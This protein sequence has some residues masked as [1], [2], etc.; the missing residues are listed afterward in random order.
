MRFRSHAPIANLQQMTIQTPKS[1]PSRTEPVGSELAATDRP[2]LYALLA[3]LGLALFLRLWGITFG[4]PYDFTPD[5]VHEI[6]RALKL[7]AGEYAWT[8]GKGGLYYFLFVEYGLLY[9]FYWITGQV[10]NPNDF[11]LL[12]LENP[13]AFYI[14][15]RVTVAIMGT[16]TCF[17]I[18]IIG[19][20][21]YDWRTGLA[22]ALIGATAHYHGLWSH[23]INVD[24]GMTLAVWASILSYI[25]YER[26]RQLR[27]LLAAGA[28][29][30]I[31]YAFKLPGAVVILLLLLAIATRLHQWS[32]PLQPIKEAGLV[33]LAMLVT[34]AIIAPENIHGMGG[35]FNNFSS[36]LANDSNE[37]LA[38]SGP[39]DEDKIDAAVDEVT[40]YR[41]SLNYLKILF[42][43]TNIVLTLGA[44][45][46]AA[47]GLRRRHRW[48]GL[49]FALIVI[50]LGVMALADRPG[51]ERYMLPIVPAFWLLGARAAVLLSRQR[52]RLMITIIACIIVIPLFSLVRQ[53]YTWTRP[54]TRVLAKDWIE[55]NIPS[56]AKILMDGMRYR[57]IGSPPLN[58]D[59][60]TVER[61]VR[62]A[63]DQDG[64]L[65]RG[66]SEKSLR[67]YSEAMS[68]IDG[69][70]YDLH[71]TVWGIDVKE[72]SFYPQ[73]CFDYIVTS[74]YNSSR[75]LDQGVAK[76][77]PLS[78][79]FYSDLPVDPRFQTVFSIKPFPWKVQGPEITVYKVLH[80]CGGS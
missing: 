74:S 7:G 79:Q 6:V 51:V 24:I 58:P 15:G 61:R 20:R 56:G 65:S 11:A 13:S 62:G 76:R 72:L 26:N 35:V 39:D 46:G 44:L 54:D 9:V 34:T 57:F 18:Y 12:Y 32:R 3:V 42:S 41:G 52:D 37:P 14:A 59:H 80:S 75:F 43:N 19:R 45:V 48:D 40:I 36:L 47:V 33:I 63:L 16:L 4:L 66:I 8:A 67:L 31:A 5:E 23:Y 30:G 22:A 78:A 68:K 49:W 29:A 10:S 71:S 60:T 1:A 70:R 2:V 38:N 77:F 69:P 21:L 27:W 64:G 73:M 55:S 25:S 53:N 50:F 28:L 17:V